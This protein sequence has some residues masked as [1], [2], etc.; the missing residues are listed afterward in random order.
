MDTSTRLD[1]LRA[2]DELGVPSAREVAEHLGIEYRVAAV[3]LL[4]T[5]RVGLVWRFRECTKDLYRYDLTE[6]GQDRLEYLEAVAQAD[7]ADDLDAE[8]EA[9][10]EW[11]DDGDD[12]DW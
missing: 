12:G 9:D 11:F 1:L 7:A 8:D 5:T 3:A 10:E 4:R 2:V 6:R